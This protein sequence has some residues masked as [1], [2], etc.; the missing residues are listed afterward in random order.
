MARS[1][2]KSSRKKRAQRIVAPPFVQIAV[3]TGDGE[4]TDDVLY[5][6]DADGRIW[7]ATMQAG[8]FGWELLG[9]H[10]FLR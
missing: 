3:S 2:K 4:S 8:M 6:L 7:T 9:N 10:T 1:K 5:A